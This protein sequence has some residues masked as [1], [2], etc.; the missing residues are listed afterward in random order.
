MITPL[1]SARCATRRTWMHQTRCKPITSSVRGTTRHAFLTGASDVQISR[2]RR[3]IDRDFSR[4]LLHTLRGV[5][6]MISA[7]A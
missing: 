4:P 1:P 6:Y 3:K 5:G 2:L 7:D